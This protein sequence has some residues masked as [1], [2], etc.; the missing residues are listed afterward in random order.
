MSLPTYTINILYKL[1][2][3]TTLYIHSLIKGPKIMLTYAVVIFALAAIG[4]AILASSVLRNKLASW[5]LSL[6]HALAGATGLILLIIEAIQGNGGSRIT[7]AL[8]LLIIAALG[9]FYLASFHLREKIAPRGFV[10]MHAGLAV[11]G[12]LTLLSILL[13]F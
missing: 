8:A 1:I 12:F 3:D 2:N 7:A 11:V 9:G 4:G 13:N 6:V 5:K 10:I